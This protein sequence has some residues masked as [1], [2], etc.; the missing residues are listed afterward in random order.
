MGRRVCTSGRLSLCPSRAG[1]ASKQ[2]TVE[3]NAVFIARQHSN[4]DA[5]YSCSNSV[6]LPVCPSVCLSRS[7]VVSNRLNIIVVCSSAYASPIILV[8]PV[9]NVFAKF[10]QSPPYGDGI[11]MEYINFAIFCQIYRVAW[12]QPRV[13]QMFPPREENYPTLA[14][15][16]T[17]AAASPMHSHH[18]LCFSHRGKLSPRKFTVATIGSHLTPVGCN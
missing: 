18:H 15:M 4:A 9:L 3:H 17:V 8:F 7:G 6:R 5:R 16:L 11:Q 12:P 13:S 14:F 2:K 1:N 10:R